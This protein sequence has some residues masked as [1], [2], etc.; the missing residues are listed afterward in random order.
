MA[1]VCLRAGGYGHGKVAERR[2]RLMA[3]G[4]TEGR[5]S[6]KPGGSEN[7]AIGGSF[8]VS[9]LPALNVPAGP[10]MMAA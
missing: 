10:T 8:L 5:E 2:R 7:D 3:T 9:W 4:P 1:R 6:G